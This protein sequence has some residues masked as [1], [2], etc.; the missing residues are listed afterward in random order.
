M[1]LGTPN[2]HLPRE[3]ALPPRVEQ[4]TQWVEQRVASSVP[5]IHRRAVTTLI[6]DNRQ[7]YVQ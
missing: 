6:L 4:P 3:F 1:K 2:A 7:A 5:S